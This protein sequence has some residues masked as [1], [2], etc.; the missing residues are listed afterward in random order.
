[1]ANTDTPLTPKQTAA[2]FD[3]LSHHNT[4]GEIR[5]FRLPGALEQ[6]G[7]PFT[8]YPKIPSTSPA[9]QSLVSKFATT[10]PGVKD[11]PPE[12]WLVQVKQLMENL[13]LANLSESYDLGVIGSRKT[14]ATAVSALLEYP[15][16]GT[17]GGFSK[18]ADTNREYD[19]S[20]PEDLIRA[21]RNFMDGVIYGTMLDRLVIK[22]AETDRLEEHEP[23]VQALHEFVLV[24]MASFIH[25]ILILSPQG[26]YLLKLLAN[27][28][29][30]IPYAV[31][32]Q[33][34]KIGN[35]ATML[36]AMVRVIL[37]KISVSSMT[38]WIGLTQHEDTGMNLMQQIISTV[39][40]WDNKDLERR[41]SKI[42][43]DK[44]S[45]AQ[46]QL[47]CLLDYTMKSRE[48]QDQIRAQS[49]NTGISI[50]ISILI[51]SEQPSDL[52]EDV[53]QLALEYLSSL[54]AIRD[55][56]EIIRVLC[57]SSPGH[58]TTAVRSVVSAYEPVIRNVHNAVDL[59]DT[60]ADFQS[61]LQD[62]IAI[63]RIPSPSKAGETAIPTVGDFVMLLKKHQ[64]SCHKFLHQC[65]KNGKELTGW[66]LQ[67][68]KAAATQFRQEDSTA[69]SVDAAGNLTVSLNDLFQKLLAEEQNDFRQILD[70]HSK[71]LDEMHASSKARLDLVLQSGPSKNP[72]NK[73]VLAAT[74]SQFSRSTSS[75]T[76]SRAP[77][78]TNLFAVTA[79]SSSKDKNYGPGAYLTRTYSFVFRDCVLCRLA[80]C[81][82]SRNMP[83]PLLLQL[84]NFIILLM[85]TCEIQAGKTFLTIH[86]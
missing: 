14:L 81:C 53:H 37:A 21:F 46:A 38:N 32:R 8:V 51:A 33:T 74:G 86:H 68:A 22:T 3:I 71:Y 59:S 7:P 56:K 76:P 39:L 13:E 75:P 25:F 72:A 34:L 69:A 80:S 52:S 23:L 61:F 84:H 57:K 16:R 60:V 65:C 82:R 27:A 70:S 42:Q 35:V 10:L 63:G 11:L 5:D 29:K 17:A 62:L 66:Y 4:Y 54:L 6:Y 40:G 79:G 55:R 67:W 48:E 12:F 73:K 15:A 2:L 77:S 9:L 18:V 41:V 24:N 31:I 83:V 19:T 26:Q 30:L 47:R 20:N 78:P 49:E 58:L 50:V 43:K 36:S 85:L 64:S 28:N 1:M 44:K 45:P